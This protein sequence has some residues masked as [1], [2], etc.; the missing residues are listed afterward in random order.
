MDAREYS[1]LVD[2]LRAV[3]DPR[4]ARGKRHAW[5]VVLTLI[6]AA[7]LSGQQG[8]RAI[9]QWVR[10]RAEDL[11]ALLR[12]PR[13]R[14][15]STSTL[16]RALRAVDLEALE[17][18]LA[19]FAQGLAAPA[20]PAGAAAPRWAG[21]A[22]DGKALRGASRHG[23]SVHLVS[24]TR[25]ADGVV[26]GQV[27]VDGKSNEITA[28]PRLLAGRD[29]AGTVTTVDALLTQ[30]ALAAQIR[31]QGG[32]YLM[33]VKENQPEL[34]AALHR[35][36]TEPPP[37]L[38]SDCA[39][40]RTA[41]EKGHGRLETRTLE[42]RAALTGHVDWP[43]L[44]QVL[45]RT[46]RAVELKTGKV[47]AEVNYGVTSLAP[48]EA[49][50]GVTSLAPGEASAAA[51]EA[52]WRG[53]WTIETRVHRVRD[54]TMGED[55]GQQRVGHAPQALAAL[56]KGLRSLLR[57]LGWANIADALRHYG[58]YPERAVRLLGVPADGL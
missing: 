54:A 33:V 8:V 20:A 58:A 15:P 14:L 13:G 43:G 48:G 50:Y 17:G 35:L 32:H 26:L 12:P 3:P 51:V 25:H 37:P 40:A 49:N 36:F 41:T 9:G 39:E 44:G 31:R 10:E 7:L 4:K 16:R 57:S 52:L 38:A 22:L 46:Y 1:S 56:R 11:R 55:A 45:R 23:A 21:Q 29:L 53:H 42:R 19:Q 24:L 34:H 47:S 5:P 27:A 30:R 6:G 2:A 18:R 28:A